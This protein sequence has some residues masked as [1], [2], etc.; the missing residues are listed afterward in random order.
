MHMF[1]HAQNRKVEKKYKY[2]K[3]GE[4]NLLLWLWL[5]FIVP[6]AAMEPIAEMN[7]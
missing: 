2:L 5:D 1:S 6:W 4:I 7:T 3:E